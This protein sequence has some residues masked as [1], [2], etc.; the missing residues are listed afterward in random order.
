MK[1]SEVNKTNVRIVVD[2]IK[3]GRYPKTEG[4]LCRMHDGAI[5]YCCLGV[6][7]E[8]FNI[9]FPGTLVISGEVAVRIYNGHQALLPL[10]VAEWLGV[11]AMGSGDGLVGPEED[12]VNIRGRDGRHASA[13]NDNSETW[14][15]VVEWFESEVL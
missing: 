14:A 10:P 7:C 11:P 13:V 4:A 8:E 3:S 12:G 9:L 15:P 5:G 2:A 1:V 6:A